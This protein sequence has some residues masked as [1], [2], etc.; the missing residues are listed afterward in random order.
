[1]AAAPGPGWNCQNQ[2]GSLAPFL[3][4]SPDL[5]FTSSH[6]ES[7]CCTSDSFRSIKMN[8]LPPPKLSLLVY[9]PSPEAFNSILS[10]LLEPSPALFNI[11]IP[12]LHETLKTTKPLPKT[13]GELVDLLAQIVETW[14]IDDRADFLRC[15]PRIGETGRMSANSTAEQQVT[16]AGEAP[17]EVL[18]RLTVS[19]V[20]DL[21]S[22]LCGSA[23]LDLRW[24][25]HKM[26]CHSMD[27]T[28]TTC[29]LLCLCSARPHHSRF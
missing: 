12:Q 28:D 25:Y 7:H 2:A 6:L 29:L 13:Y 15:H 16:A 9:S 26:L 20:P 4:L 21:L 5:L 23:T 14:D 1:M 8:H 18:K 17:G 27:S 10:T 24:I 3:D 22:P 19:L 11:L